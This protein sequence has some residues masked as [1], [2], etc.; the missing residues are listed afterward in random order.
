MNVDEGQISQVISNLVINAQQAMPQGGVIGMR[1]EDVVVSPENGLPIAPGEYVRISIQ[2][3]GCG[4]PEDHFSKI[5]DPYFTT[6]PKGSGLG[7]ATSYSIIKKHEGLIAV[8]SS[9]GVGTTFDVYLP[10]SDEEITENHGTK[11][12]LLTGKAKILLMDDEQI[13]GDL[14]EEMLGMLGYDVDVANDGAEAVN[15][16]QEA[17]KTWE[18][19]DLVVVD[20]TVPGGMGGKEAIDI[21]RKSDPD[22]R[23]IV[24][25]GY[26]NDPIMANYQK[27]GFMGV[28]AKPYTVHDLSEAVRQALLMERA[29]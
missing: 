24:S 6:K 27:H 4:I 5:F 20:L 3:H 17:M 21:L 7:L 10:R 8:S 19:Y 11:L 25:S 29:E 13:I 9:V 15:L 12:R 18:P 22:I 1:V 28:V 26:S 23:A 16:Y 2:D 14:A